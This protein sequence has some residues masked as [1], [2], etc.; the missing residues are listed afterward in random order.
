MTSTQCIALPR[1]YDAVR[2]A[3][4]LLLFTWQLTDHV[5]DLHFRVM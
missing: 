4:S 1:T 3:L 2:T 5:T